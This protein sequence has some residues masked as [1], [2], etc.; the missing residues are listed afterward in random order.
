MTKT[1]LTTFVPLYSFNNTFTLKILLKIVN[2]IH[3]KHCSGFLCIM[4]MQWIFPPQ[5]PPFWRLERSGV[6]MQ[7]SRFWSF[8]CL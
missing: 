5:F 2:K 7:C 4:D 1:Q 3:H 6:A 8:Q